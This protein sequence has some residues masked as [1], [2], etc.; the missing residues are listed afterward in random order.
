MPEPLPAEIR[1]GL[2]EREVQHTSRHHLVPRE[3]GGHHGPIVDLCQP[4]HSTVHLLLTNREL[5]RRYNTVERLRAAE[6]LQKYLHWVRRNRV[7]RIS[8]RRARRG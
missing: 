1:C 6:E 3:E 7:E 8:N 2:C 5:A 4:C